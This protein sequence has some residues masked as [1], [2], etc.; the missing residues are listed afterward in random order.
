VA[1]ALGTAVMQQLDA[2][3]AA[4]G[5]EIDATITVDVGED[6]IDGATD[7]AHAKIVRRFHE[8]A[9]RVVAKHRG[10]CA[11]QEQQVEIAIVIEI[12]EVYLSRPTN[13]RYP[14]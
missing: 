3:R 9:V 14:G 11:A 6:R 8:G 2:S 7:G 4:D 13:V 5:D 10:G 1:E 12:D